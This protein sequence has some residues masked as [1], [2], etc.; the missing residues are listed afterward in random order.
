MN[1]IPEK[2]VPVAEG[3]NAMRDLFTVCLQRGGF[4]TIEENAKFLG[5]YSK[6][7]Y[8]INQ[9]IDKDMEEPAMEPKID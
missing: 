8:H 5:A 9:M 7:E 1:K 4:K 2:W 6:L 3:V